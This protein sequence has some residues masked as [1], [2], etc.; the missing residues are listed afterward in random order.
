MRGVVLE[1][2]F[3]KTQNED[4]C[5]S[6]V[7]LE[8]IAN[9]VYSYILVDDERQILDCYSVFDFQRTISTWDFTKTKISVQNWM[10]IFLKSRHKLNLN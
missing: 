7:Y 4:P 8:R 9:K 5:S 6:V 10:D 3:D 2:H 1:M